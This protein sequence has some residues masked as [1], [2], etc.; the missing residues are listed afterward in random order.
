M[1]P[2]HYAALKEDVDKLLARKFIRE[3]HYPIWVANPIL[4]KKNRKWRTWVDFTDLNKACPKDSFPFPMIDSLW[5][6]WLVT[7]S[8]ALWMHIQVITRFLCT[9]AMRSTPHL[10][11]IMDYIA[12]R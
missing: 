10:L 11:P 1:T 4:V 6:Q 8:S 12:I 5:M 7:S 2:E 3:A 9:L